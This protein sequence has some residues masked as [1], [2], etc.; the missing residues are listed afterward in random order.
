MNARDRDQVHLGHH[1]A[2]SEVGQALDDP[3]LE[4]SRGELDLRDGLEEQARA[5]KGLRILVDRAARLIGKIDSKDRY[6]FADQPAREMWPNQKPPFVQIV[7]FVDL[8]S[9][10]GQRDSCDITILLELQSDLVGDVRV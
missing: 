9:G 7:K 3:A 2:L 4:K 1:E 6:F 10:Q 8:R 5:P